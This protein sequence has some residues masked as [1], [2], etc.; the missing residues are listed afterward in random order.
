MVARLKVTSFYTAPTALRALMAHGDAFVTAHDRSSVRVLGTVG[1]PINPEAWQW[2]F[3]V[4]G[5]GRCSVVDTYWQTETGGHLL[6]PLPGKTPLKAGSCALPFYGVEPVLLDPA[7]GAE[8]AGNEVEGALAIKRA[9]PGMARTC[10]GDHQ[11][12]VATYLKAYD[13]YFFTGDGCKRDKD[14]YY[15]IT[16]R[17]DDVLN[18]SGHRL[19][20]AEIEAALCA[21]HGCTE[22]AVV[23]FPHDLKGQG[24]CCY[25]VLPADT[26]DEAAA[27]VLL[28]AQVRAAIGAFATPDLIVPIPGLPKTRSGKIMRRILRKV[29][30]AEEESLGDIST[31]SDPSVVEAIIAKVKAVQGR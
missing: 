9:W 14:G 20:T 30:V 13:G 29:V 1:E 27:V 10:Y 16:G 11:R 23:G 26:P 3:D 28:K 12:F 25:V 15:W 7:T 6:T 19:G 31:L 5:E 2:Y 21:H 18:V 17:V 4:V 8:L 22:A 24:I